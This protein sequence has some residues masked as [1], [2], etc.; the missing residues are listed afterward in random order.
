MLPAR[1]RLDGLPCYPRVLEGQS[2]GTK[3]QEVMVLVPRC[4]VRA[5]WVS[6]NCS[7]SGGAD[8]CHRMNLAVFGSAKAQNE[9]SVQ[10]RSQF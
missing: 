3:C 5:L 4:S 9:L 2:Q 1:Q 10:G 7:K 8:S 6:L